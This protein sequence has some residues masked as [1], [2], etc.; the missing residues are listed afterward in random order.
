MSQQLADLLFPDVKDTVEYYRNQYPSRIAWQKVTRFAPSPT[1]FLHI[2]GVYSAYISQRLAHQWWENGIFFLRIEDTDQKRQVAWACDL[3][4]NG[5]KRFGIQID[6]G[7]IWP[8]NAAVGQYGPYVQSERKDIYAVFVKHFVAA[9]LAYPCW[10][11]ES[12]IE[13]TRTMQ[14]A[15]KKVPG[16]YGHYSKW[17]D[18]S[19]E[20]QQE[21]IAS[22]APFVIRFKATAHLGDKVVVKDVIK[23]DVVT[24]DNF[25]DMVLLKSTDGLPTYHMAH[26]VDDYLMWTTHVVRGDEWFASMPF[27]LQLFAALG[28]E[29]P[30]YCHF[31]PLLKL[32]PETANKRK[33]SKRHD[34]EANVEYFFQQWIPTDAILEFLTNIVDP[35]FEERQKNNIDKTYKDYTFD[36]THMNQAGALLDITKLY[37]VS[38]EWLARLSKE[39]F[40]KR[41]LEWAEEYGE[42]MSVMNNELH[43]VDLMKKYPEYTF[44]ALNIERLTPADPK[45][46]RMFS[47]ILIQLPV[48]Y[49]EVYEK[50]VAKKPQ[51]PEACSPENMKNFLA[52]YETVL[53][54]TMTKE[55]W[56][57]Q[58]KDVGKKYAFAPSNSEFKE[59]GYVGR[60]GDLAMFFRVQLMC[61]PTT[62]DLYESMKVMWKERVLKRLAAI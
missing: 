12:E 59:W 18:A 38:K 28:V 43:I 53:D 44:D 31:S 15:A 56:F 3:I 46:Y 1:G 8:S 17:R 36:I 22:G 13:A 58:F 24:Q 47:D 54:L 27:H 20:T 40:V 39:E 62:P 4:I 16:I 9:W 60:I 34:P 2:G 33:L 11:S 21:M 52:E 50:I 61:S 19:F 32:D 55:D 57:V 26:L 51:L 48:F 49:D 5:L 30:S 37:F 7:P 42:E 10:M 35:F 14:Q 6:E 41:A 23:G 25:I 45:R 29:A